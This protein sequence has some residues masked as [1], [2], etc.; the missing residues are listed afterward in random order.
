MTVENYR[1]PVCGWEPKEYEKE[2]PQDDLS[3]C[4]N[5]LSSIHAETEDGIDCGGTLEPISICIDRDEQWALIQRCSCCGEIRGEWINGYYDSPIKIL[6]L[7]MK[8]LSSPPFPLEKMEELTE[9]MG[10]SGNIGGYYEQG[11]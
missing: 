3:H 8:P 7:A 6:S 4:P 5:C 1:C 10:G 11:K 9:I 2:Y